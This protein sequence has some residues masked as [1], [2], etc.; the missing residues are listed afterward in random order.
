MK[1]GQTLDYEFRI[2]HP[3]GSVRFIWDRSFP[4]K[5]EKG[6]IKRFIGIAQDVTTWRRS[7]E[8]LKESMD[9]LDQIINCI[10]DPVFVKDYQ[11][12]LVLVNEAM[13]MFSGIPREELLGKTGF[14]LVSEKVAGSLHEQE[15]E[16]FRTGKE[17]V[18]EDTLPDSD[19][20]E[21]I[22][23]TKKTLLKKKSGEKQIVGVVRDITEYK[24]L[25][26]QFLHAQKME[27]VGSL[28]GGGAH[29]FNNLL[30]DLP[31]AGLQSQTDIESQG[32][33]SE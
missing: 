10:S 8:A 20:N 21:H 11:Y 32:A 14:D 1:S 18:G 5:D 15:A 2:I 16:V 4:I 33:R 23:M 7:E 22:L 24:R 28:A 17:Y 30:T 27:A 29:D 25:E 9:Y 13:S 3:D 26:A 31:A 12:R 19:G 6:R